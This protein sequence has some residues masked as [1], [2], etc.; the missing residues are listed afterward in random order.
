MIQMHFY[1]GGCD[2][3]VAEYSPEQPNFF[4]YAILNDDFVNSLW[5]YTSIDDL[6]AVNV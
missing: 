1:L 3:C 6:R 4:C 5:G 2:W